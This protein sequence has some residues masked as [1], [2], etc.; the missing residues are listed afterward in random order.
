M[1]D[2]IPLNNNDVKI[3]ESGQSDIIIF[4]SKK[5]QRQLCKK[6]FHYKEE[7]F[8][9]KKF[10][11]EILS[12]FDD[13]QKKYFLE[14]LFSND[15]D[16]ELIFP[17]ISQV[18]YGECS[19]TKGIQCVNHLIYYFNQIISTIKHLHDKNIC[20]CDIKV[21][22]ILI[23]QDRAVIIDFGH[24]QHANKST[25]SQQRCGTKDFN[26]P[27]F[28]KSFENNEK[29][30]AKIEE[31][32]P[33]E[34]DVYQLGMLLF[35]MAAFIKL[36]DA[37]KIVASKQN[38][39]SFFKQKIEKIYLEKY[40]KQLVMD[41]KLFDLIC[42]ILS[43]QI[44]EVNQI[45]QSQLYVDLL[46]Q[47][48]VQE[49]V[50]QYEDMKQINKETS[51]SRSSDEPTSFKL[52]K[53]Y[54][55]YQNLMKD[56]NNLEQF[57]ECQNKFFKQEPRVIE[58]QKLIGGSLFVEM[59]TQD[60]LKA[61]LS[62]LAENNNEIFNQD[63]FSTKDS[64]TLRVE[65]IYQTVETVVKDHFYQIL[66]EEFNSEDLDEEELDELIQTQKIGKKVKM[67]IEIVNV[68]ENGKQD[69]RSLL[70]QLID[71]EY[72]YY[73]NLVQEIKEKICKF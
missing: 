41:P 46:K 37:L 28:N 6:K 33:Q 19:Q 7:Y 8:I 20:H 15:N 23:K 25:K 53:A 67:S 11:L 34:L 13:N 55:Y 64:L 31:Y 52:A 45:Q 63:V 43:F 56:S 1:E 47:I 61:L 69:M 10:Y 73:F 39:K 17:N 5:T 70:F 14:L 32:S 44:T 9:E 65:L 49:Q 71:G 62:I 42:Q 48:N 36:D 51:N 68:F 4:T 18:L 16:H 54:S 57:K 40:E 30:N 21:Q 72:L 50:S 58:R 35:T 3:I 38:L 26:P 59:D 12:G 2:Y 22:N 29:F 60:L 24:Y 66:E 27:K